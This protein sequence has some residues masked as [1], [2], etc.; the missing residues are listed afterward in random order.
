MNDVD[1]QNNNSIKNIFEEIDNQLINDINVENILNE[2]TTKLITIPMNIDDDVII[3]SLNL[4]LP[5]ISSPV[6]LDNFNKIISSFTSLVEILN[7]YAE[8][9]SSQL[10][11]SLLPSILPIELHFKLLSIKSIFLNIYSHLKYLLILNLKDFLNSNA[12]PLPPLLIFPSSPSLPSS[13]SSLLPLSNHSYRSPRNFLDKRSKSILK[14]WFMN[15]LQYPYPSELEKHSLCNQCNISIKQLNT[16]FAN[17]R[18]RTK[19][20][21]INHETPFQL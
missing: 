16:W 14:H 8:Y 19:K 20:K 13:L 11:S 4:I 18:S 12:I 9:Y 15:H 6:I 10:N 7:L 21:F 2:V 1:K 3:N 5:S 17:Y